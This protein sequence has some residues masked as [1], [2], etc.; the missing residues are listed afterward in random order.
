MSK[1]PLDQATSYEIT[2][3]E[4]GDIRYTRDWLTNYGKTHGG[5]DRLILLTVIAKVVAFIGVLPLA[6]WLGST[7]LGIAAKGM[8]MIGFLGS[9]FLFD[10]VML[11][12]YYRLRYAFFFL[13]IL[14]GVGCVGVALMGVFIWG[15]TQL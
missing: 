10:I 8:T 11:F 15:L 12:R 7:H 5:R 2:M 6:F 4:A 14:I 1:E 9:I 13:G 3:N